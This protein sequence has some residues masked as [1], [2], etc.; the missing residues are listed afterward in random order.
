MDL[1]DRYPQ[2]MSFFSVGAG[3]KRDDHFPRSSVHTKHSYQ[4]L[5]MPLWPYITDKSNQI[6]TKENVK[7]FLPQMT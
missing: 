3:S 7:Y 2:Y 5:R 4:G 6:F 1:R